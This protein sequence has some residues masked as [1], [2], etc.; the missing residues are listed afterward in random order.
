MENVVK[1]VHLCVRFLVPSFLVCELDLVVAAQDGGNLLFVECVFND[2]VLVEVGGIILHVQFV[3]SSSKEL[4]L[5]FSAASAL[6]VQNLLVL[7]GRA[8][9]SAR[10]LANFACSCYRQHVQIEHHVSEMVG[11]ELAE[12]KL[13][14]V[15]QSGQRPTTVCALNGIPCYYGGVS[16]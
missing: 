4:G 13:M 3:A 14:F 10:R 9:S 8:F 1:L 12:F 2:R 11:T 15:V 5:A 7:S 6:V 16:V